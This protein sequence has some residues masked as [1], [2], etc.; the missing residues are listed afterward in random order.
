MTTP[1]EAAQ[2]VVATDDWNARVALIRKVPESF[3]TA[4]HAVVYST[5]ARKAYK[6]LRRALGQRGVGQER[7]GIEVDR[8]VISRSRPAASPP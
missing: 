5:I 8:L 7:A 3:G 4:Q 6:C 1:N 2:E